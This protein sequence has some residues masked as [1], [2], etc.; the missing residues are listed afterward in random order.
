MKL[1][2]NSQ[3]KCG[4]SKIREIKI[5]KIY[6]LNDK[7]LENRD[8]LFKW[9]VNMHN[10]VDPNKKRSTKDTYNYYIYKYQG[11]EVKPIESNNY[12]SYKNIA[13]VSCIIIS[14]IVIHKL[15]I[16]LF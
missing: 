10:A 11:N 1:F 15:Y 7:V 16:T 9:I 12:D 5:D 8:S 6:P 3:R 13:T 14:L 4:I 2:S